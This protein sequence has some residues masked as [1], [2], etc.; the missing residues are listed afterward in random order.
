MTETL[1]HGGTLIDGGGGPATPADILVREGLIAVIGVEA[2]AA[3]AVE[4]FDAPGCF[5]SPGWIDIHAHVYNHG[6]FATSRLDADRVGVRQGVA[7]LVDAGSAGA[8]SIDGFPRFVHD[9]QQTPVYA[10]VNVG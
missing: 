6:V 2:S 4:T 7:C 9:T 3:A 5:V 1:I 8:L 10:L